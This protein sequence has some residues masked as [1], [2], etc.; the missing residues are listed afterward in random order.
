MANA[1]AAAAAVAAAT[2]ATVAAA[3]TAGVTAATVTAAVAGRVLLGWRRRLLYCSPSLSF[4]AVLQFK[5]TARTTTTTTIGCLFVCWSA[6][7]RFLCSS[8][9]F[10]IALDA[11]L[12]FFSPSRGSSR[13]IFLAL[14]AALYAFFCTRVNL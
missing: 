1:A 4:W 3:A 8:S 5:T 7:S 2:A 12:V 13:S 11:V 14:G 10:C 9:S 6:I